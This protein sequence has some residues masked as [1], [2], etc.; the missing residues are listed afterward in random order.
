MTYDWADSDSAVILDRSDTFMNEVCAFVHKAQWHSERVL[1]H[2]VRG[3]SRSCCILA[4]CLMKLY[5]S[6]LRSTLQ[7]L[8]AVRPDLAIRPSFL[9]QLAA[10]ECR[11]R[12]DT[13]YP[14]NTERR[15]KVDECQSED[16]QLLWRYDPRESGFVSNTSRGQQS[17]PA[18]H[19]HTAAS[20]AVGAGPSRQE[21]RVFR[22][23]PRACAELV[24]GACGR[25][26]AGGAVAQEG[27]AA[28]GGAQEVPS[29]RKSPEGDAAAGGVPGAL[30][31]IVVK[32]AV[33]P[34]PPERS[35]A[36]LPSGIAPT[37]ANV[38]VA[39][40][41]QGCVPPAERMPDEAE[42]AGG[43]TPLPEDMLV[44]ASTRVASPKC[45]RSRRLPQC[46][47]TSQRR[48]DSSSVRCGSRRRSIGSVGPPL[49]RLASST[50][51]CP[52]KMD[53]TC[54]M[55]SNSHAVDGDRVATVLWTP[56]A[57]RRR[58]GSIGPPPLQ[59]APPRRGTLSRPGSDST[60]A[61]SPRGL[62]AAAT[63]VAAAS[64]AV[65]AA[66]GVVAAATAAAAAAALLAAAGRITRA[67]S[68][69][70]EYP[71]SE[72]ATS[73]G[74]ESTCVTSAPRPGRP[75]EGCRPHAAQGAM[76]AFRTGGPVKARYD[77]FGRRRQ[78]GPGF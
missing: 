36:N 22:P 13:L 25:E 63:A 28:A 15:A 53:S 8:Q 29:G 19:R 6:S 38:L 56:V 64:A 10:F 68:S 66:T 74:S 27:D 77:L 2:S 57:C 41:V 23:L 59:S 47:S 76:E 58:I 30:R 69:T 50:P 62:D 9:Q 52:G 17:S 26:A 65:A 61:A 32:P 49:L 33:Q 1:I 54:C 67:S 21:Q 4:A 73:S 55:V 48:S 31:G 46:Q 18:A 35:G 45:P 40:A 42:V 37:E 14:L 51:R 78:H 75:P 44:L 71:S 72:S 3:Q 60:P 70:S 20:E 39:T 16:T 43:A 34:R 11:L 12:A 7:L 5:R 24:R